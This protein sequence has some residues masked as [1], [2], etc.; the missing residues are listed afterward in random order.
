MS[1]ETDS[2]IHSW[3]SDDLVVLL[4]AVLDSGSDV[5]PNSDDDNIDVADNDRR[6]KRLKVEVLKDTQVSN[7]YGSSK[8]NLDGAI[9]ALCP[10]PG[11][12][13][14]LCYRCGER[15]NDGGG[16]PFRY[17]H[18]GLRLRTDEISRLRD[19]DVRSALGFKK[20]YL[21]LDLDH[22]LLNSS[23]LDDISS[24]EEY[25]LSTQ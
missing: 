15:K 6:C 14:N 11:F 17:I 3:S 13:R 25:L 10:H 20:L 16:V 9:K 21:I 5:P 19:S 1:V 4:D 22:T 12:F 24:E 8:E 23:R 7:S 18:E 2:P